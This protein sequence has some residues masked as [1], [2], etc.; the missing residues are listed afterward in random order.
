[1]RATRENQAIM[2]RKSQLVDYD[3]TY[4][5][6]AK[7]NAIKRAN[8][9]KQA[10]YYKKGTGSKSDLGAAEMA[11]VSAKYTAD[12]IKAMYKA[13][14]ITEIQAK[15]RKRNAA[16]IQAMLD[17]IRAEPKK[18]VE[19]QQKIIDNENAAM[20]HLNHDSK[21]VNEYTDYTTLIQG[22]YDEHF[23]DNS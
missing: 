8:A 1:M 21:E 2:A 18:W 4:E 12:R 20:Y 3:Y 22:F 17:A 15:V 9:A 16:R 14:S 19:L 5:Q 13:P 6:R 7:V 23:N 11:P 10:E